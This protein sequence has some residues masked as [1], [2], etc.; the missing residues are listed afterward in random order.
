MIF[1]NAD[2]IAPIVKGFEHLMWG[3][4]AATTNFVRVLCTNKSLR[5][6]FSIFLSYRLDVI[7][8]YVKINEKSVGK[9]IEEQWWYL[10][11][12]IQ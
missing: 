5:R 4:A 7:P 2:S 8:S 10:R 9:K 3:S 12:G 6:V 1:E 11:D